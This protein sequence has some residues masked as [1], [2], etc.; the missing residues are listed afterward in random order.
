MCMC[1]VQ[2]IGHVHTGMYVT[3]KCH[4]TDTR[5][6]GRPSGVI[7]IG[8]EHRGMG[9]PSAVG[10]GYIGVGGISQPM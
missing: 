1:M 5:C 3:N 10:L 7:E 9:E 8:G 2:V 4:P 6:K